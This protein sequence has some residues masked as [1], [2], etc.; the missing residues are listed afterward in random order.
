MTIQAQNEFI[1]VLK[2]M[3]NYWMKVE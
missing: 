1:A 2:R 3:V